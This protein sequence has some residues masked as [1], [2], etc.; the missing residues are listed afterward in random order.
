MLTVAPGAVP[1]AVVD[2]FAAVVI[3]DAAGNADHAIHQPFNS[4]R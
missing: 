4:S 1:V 2:V 3:I